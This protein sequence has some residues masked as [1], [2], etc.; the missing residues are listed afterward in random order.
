MVMTDELEKV[1]EGTRSPWD[2][3]RTG[4]RQQEVNVRDFIQQNYEPYEGDGGFLEAATDRTNR[5]WRGLND[6]FVEERRK[7]VLDVSQ[8]PSTIPYR[9]AAD[10]I[11]LTTS[12]IAEGPGRVREDRLAN[13]TSI[14]D[15]F[16]RATGYHMNIN[17]LNRDTLIDAMDHPEG[18]PNLTIRVSGYAVNFVRLPRDQQMDVINRTFHGAELHD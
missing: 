3:F 15:A 8:V 4:L 10:G 7:G 17:V 16:F 14:L 5:I 6:L 2:G 13:L 18:Y 1:R 12:M 11:S 9:D